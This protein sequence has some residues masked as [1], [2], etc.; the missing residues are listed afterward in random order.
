VEVGLVAGLIPLKA[1]ERRPRLIRALSLHPRWQ[2]VADQ[3]DAAIQSHGR[4]GEARLREERVHLTLSRAG[5]TVGFNHYLTHGSEFDQHVAYALLGPDGEELL[6]RD[7]KPR[8]IQVAVPGHLA[9]DAAH[10]HFSIDDVRARGDVPNLVNEFLEAWSYRLAHPG[11]QSRTLEID[12][13]MVFRSTVPAD[14]IIGFDTLT[15]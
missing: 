9:L 15:E 8:V 3:L 11:F 2:V 6:A 5:L 10:P 13:G 1:E 4:G 12:C 14:W 7:G